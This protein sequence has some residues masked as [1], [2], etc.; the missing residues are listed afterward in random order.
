MGNLLDNDAMLGQD[1]L[2]YLTGDIDAHADANYDSSGDY[3]FFLPSI[4][5]AK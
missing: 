2:A 1:I 5:T 4:M 3:N